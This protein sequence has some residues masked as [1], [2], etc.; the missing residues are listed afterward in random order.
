[1]AADCKIYDF[2]A[3]E[4]FWQE[5]WLK[6]K[7][8]RAE[9][10]DLREKYYVLDMF[11]YPSGAGLHIGHPEGYTASDILTRGQFFSLFLLIFG[12]LITFFRGRRLFI[13]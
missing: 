13:R 10:G 1:M 12:I 6:E 7:T 2:R 4:P 8:F 11:P 9:N 5:R 3:I